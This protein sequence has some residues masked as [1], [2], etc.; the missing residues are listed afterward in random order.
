MSLETIDVLNQLHW[1]KNETLFVFLLH[2]K[3]FFIAEFLHLAEPELL[4]K[5]L[6]M[7]KWIILEWFAPWMYLTTACLSSCIKFLPPANQFHGH[8]PVGAFTFLLFTPTSG[9]PFNLKTSAKWINKRRQQ[10]K[11]VNKNL[12]NNTYNLTASQ[13][14]VN[15]VI[16]PIRWF[17]SEH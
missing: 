15:S 11:K 5:D 17:S 14:T 4:Q 12:K 3:W 2:Q 1:L 9:W 13:S 10:F 7:K 16:C 6:P 8:F